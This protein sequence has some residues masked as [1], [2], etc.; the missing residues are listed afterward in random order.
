[1]EGMQQLLIRIDVHLGRHATCRLV[2]CGR[3]SH[4][5]VVAGE[6]EDEPG[7]QTAK[8]RPDEVDLQHMQQMSERIECTQVCEGVWAAGE[9]W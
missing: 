6:A 1:M 5:L 9:A 2:C 7:E 3:G 4:E 8:R